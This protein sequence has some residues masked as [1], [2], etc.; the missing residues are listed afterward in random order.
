MHSPAIDYLVCDLFQFHLRA[1]KFVKALK[2][3]AIIFATAG[4]LL[5]VYKVYGQTKK[6]EPIQRA[7]SPMN[8][9]SANSTSS[10]KTEPDQQSKY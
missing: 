4:I 9:H 5:A 8:V 3:T 2:Y 7:P 10:A 1:I 6:I